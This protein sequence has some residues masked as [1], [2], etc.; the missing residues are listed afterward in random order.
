[1]PSREC[2]CAVRSLVAQLD[3]EGE[4]PLQVVDLP[5]EVAGTA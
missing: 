3:V 4:R 2:T 1:M 5:A